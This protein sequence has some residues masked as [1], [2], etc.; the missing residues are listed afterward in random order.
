MSDPGARA[1]MSLFTPVNSRIRANVQ[2]AGDK[3]CPNKVEARCVSL[4]LTRAL[5]SHKKLFSQVEKLLR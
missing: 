5:L 4:A 3:V 1:K 2:T